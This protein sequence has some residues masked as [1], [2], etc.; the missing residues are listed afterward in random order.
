M[1]AASSRRGPSGIWATERAASPSSA[2]KIACS[3]SMSSS[4]KGATHKRAIEPWRW[5]TTNP[6]WARRWSAC[7]I[8]VRLT[9]SR[10]VSSDSLKG[11]PGDSFKATIRSRICS[12]ASRPSPSCGLPRLQGPSR[13]P[14][15]LRKWVPPHWQPQHW[16]HRLPAEFRVVPT[17]SGHHLGHRQA[18]RC[19]EMGRFVR[20]GVEESVRAAATWVRENMAEMVPNPPQVS[21]GEV[22]LQIGG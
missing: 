17:Q 16:L 2:L 19:H 6:S 13:R 4:V 12:Y 10:S 9:P 8:G 15:L 22:A 11:A 1:R 20:A 7:R 3:S 18:V 21:N 5:T 14:G